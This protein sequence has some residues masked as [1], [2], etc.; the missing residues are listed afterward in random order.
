MIEYKDSNVRG[1]AARYII[2]C[3]TKVLGKEFKDKDV[4]S[5]QII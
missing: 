3:I 4:E 5:L 1:I 2:L